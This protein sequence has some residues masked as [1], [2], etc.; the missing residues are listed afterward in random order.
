MSA[1]QASWLLDGKGA[2]DEDEADDDDDDAD[3]DDVPD[4]DTFGADAEMREGGAEIE[5]GEG[6]DE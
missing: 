1:Y 2:D 5:E 6:S 4:E 3:M